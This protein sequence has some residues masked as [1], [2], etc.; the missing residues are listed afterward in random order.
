MKKK[1]SSIILTACLLVAVPIGVSAESYQSI[2]IKSTAAQM[3]IQPR[4]DV[5]E[6]KYQVSADGKWYMRRWNV[7]RNRWVD[8]NWIAM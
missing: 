4:A 6:W 8:P 5:I 2:E 7:T 1:I 3:Q